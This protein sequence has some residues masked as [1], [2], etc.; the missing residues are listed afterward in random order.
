MLCIVVYFGARIMW[1]DYSYYNA[2]RFVRIIAI[3]CERKI[4]QSLNNS[5]KFIPVISRRFLLEKK[6]FQNG[7]SG[8]L[9]ICNS[10]CVHKY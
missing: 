4:S 7:A 9:V 10:S 5:I 3:A 8:F 6:K 2:L 1:A